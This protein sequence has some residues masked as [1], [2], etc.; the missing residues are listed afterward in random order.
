MPRETKDQ[1]ERAATGNLEAWKE[2]KRG[3]DGQE[4][5]QAQLER[6]EA[7]QAVTVRSSGL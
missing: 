6:L 1:R 5:T 4:W 2:K 7:A 3:L